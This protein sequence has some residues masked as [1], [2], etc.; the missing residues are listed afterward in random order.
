M[1]RDSGKGFE[2]D[3]LELEG[4]AKEYRRSVTRHEEEPTG[5]EAHRLVP[6]GAL[7]GLLSPV[8]RTC[9]RHHWSAGDDGWAVHASSAV[10]CRRCRP[11]LHRRHS[12]TQAPSLAGSWL[13]GTWLLCTSTAQPTLLGLPFGIA[14]LVGSCHRP[15]SGMLAS[16]LAS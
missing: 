7:A 5:K 13:R 11:P 4:G 6:L 9:T 16:R 3:P 2:A 1:G 14:A 15:C 12:T 10:A 8:S